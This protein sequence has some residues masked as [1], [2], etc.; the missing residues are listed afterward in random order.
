M[1]LIVVLLNTGQWAYFIYVST[2]VGK[3]KNNL[4]PNW[5]PNRTFVFVFCVPKMWIS[6]VYVIVAKLW[7]PP[8]PGE[9]SECGEKTV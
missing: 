6:E 1:Y 9:L 3:T 7:R 4:S 8:T 2:L 5:F